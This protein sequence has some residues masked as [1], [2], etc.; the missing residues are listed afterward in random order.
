[1]RIPNTQAD[2][3]HALG[4]RRPPHGA[5]S[6]RL[7]PLAHHAGP[8]LL[9]AAIAILITAP[10]WAQPDR[11]L[12]GPALGDNASAVWN[13]WWARTAVWDTGRSLL[14]TDAIFA[15]LGT[16]L[17]LHSTTLA[18]TVAS[19]LVWRSGEPVT[20]YN[21]WIALSLFLNGLCAYALCH[22]YTGRRGA[23]LFGGLVFALAP[24]LV[25][26]IEGHFNVLCAWV[27]PL[28]GLMVERLLRQRTIAAGI[29]AGV[30]LGL[31]AYVDYY[32]FIF[33]LVLLG[34]LAVSAVWRVRLE[35]TPLTPARRRVARVL[36]MLAGL[37]LLVSAVI[38]LT[39]GGELHLSGKVLRMRGTFNPRMLAWPLA[40]AALVAWYGTRPRLRLRLASQRDHRGDAPN[41]ARTGQ[42]LA[43]WLALGATALIAIAPLILAAGE[44]WR[45]DD[46]A[47]QRYRWRSA[48]D[49]IDAA[50]LVLGNPTSLLVGPFVRTAYARFGIDSVESVA[51]LGVVPSLLV[52]RSMRRASRT[53]D[54]ERWLIVLAFFGVW[55]L[56]PFL[57]VFGTNTA[58]VLPQTL[59]RF[60]PIVA[61]ARIPARAFTLVIL[62]V[63]VLAAMTIAAHPFFRKRFRT[64]LAI[65]LLLLDFAPAPY[66][67]TRLQRPAADMMLATLPPGVLLELPV[68]LRDGF[69]ET[70]RLDHYSLYYQ[71][72]HGHAVTGGFAARLSE[73]VKHRYQTDPIFG[74][75][76]D[77]SAGMPSAQSAEPR[78]SADS[79]A[80]AVRYVAI[81]EGVSAELLAFTRTVFILR[82]LVQA[83]PRSL[84]AVDGFQPPFCVR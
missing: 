63:A 6:A 46:Y 19:A 55:S 76:L 51:W 66:P 2:P 8:V 3:D 74:P 1:M 58:F 42:R 83:A 14:W 18:P 11:T 53:A 60:I 24:F 78:P 81:S 52:L 79:L 50:A 67:V 28:L 75:L 36:A 30:T 70:G 84:Y 5:L 17:L 4:A 61:N 34:L 54:V 69:G 48:P 27:L 37:L 49:G 41:P 31:V 12:F 32:N 9:F 40:I 33:S 22:R 57:T 45:S 23:S 72:L 73:R 35:R 80:C 13:F 20:A 44:V 62:A 59:V 68:G 10:V 82:P 7:A 56:G 21:A 77:L 15:P 43:P 71:T 38:W 47:T 25:V 26:R 29:A 16:S 65:G 39:G 64:T